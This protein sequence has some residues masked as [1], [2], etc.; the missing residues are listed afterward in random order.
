MKDAFIQRVIV[1]SRFKVLFV[2]YSIIQNIISSEKKKM[3]YTQ[4]A[5]QTCVCVCGG[6]GSLLNHHQLNEKLSF[7]MMHDE[8][9]KNWLR[10][11]LVLFSSK[12]TKPP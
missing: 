2:T 12:I 6:G 7:W 9:V 4:S 10:R 8:K 5:L 1:Y 11:I 3:L